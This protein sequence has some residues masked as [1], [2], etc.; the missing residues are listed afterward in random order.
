V[1]GI[2]LRNK[3]KKK[4]KTKIFQC[5]DLRK[6]ERIMKNELFWA[7]HAINFAFKTMC[8]ADRKLIQ[9]NHDLYST[10]EEANE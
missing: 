2:V 4:L 1:H 7:M 3:G 8:K 6:R 10:A 5:L 9:A